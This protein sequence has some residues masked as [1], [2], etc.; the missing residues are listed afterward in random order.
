MAAL[1]V[2]PRANK[3]YSLPPC[4]QPFPSISPEPSLLSRWWS[5]L[6]EFI[7]EFSSVF[8][9][10]F[11]R[12]LLITKTTCFEILFFLPFPLLTFIPFLEIPFWNSFP[13]YP[14]DLWHENKTKTQIGSRQFSFLFFLLL[15][16][17]F[18]LTNLFLWMF[19]IKAFFYYLI[20]F[21]IFI[22]IIS[23]E[24][25]W[26]GKNFLLKTLTFFNFLEISG[27]TTIYIFLNG[28]FNFKLFTQLKNAV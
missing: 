3:S 2:M 14:S 10:F 9:F 27:L 19:Y 4:F 21:V 24:G 17:I 5:S 13:N 25:V 20:F 12:F 8:S 18:F 6:M 16:G 7:L 1:C 23:V 22:I 26:I 11:F 15:E 28:F